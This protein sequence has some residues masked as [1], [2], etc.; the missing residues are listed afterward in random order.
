MIHGSLWDPPEDVRENIGKYI[1]EVRI[2]LI[3]ISPALI[4]L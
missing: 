3:A 4:N 1:D 2:S